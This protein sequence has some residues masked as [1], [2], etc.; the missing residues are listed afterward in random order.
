[1]PRDGGLLAKNETLVIDPFVHGCATA[2]AGTWHS[3]LSS[4]LPPPEDKGNP[5][6]DPWFVP[7]PLSNALRFHPQDVVL[8]TNWPCNRTLSPLSDVIRSHMELA[9]NI[10]ARCGDDIRG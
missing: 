9:D 6:P 4:K 5:T 8:W 7:A 10:N 2:N 1:M 3:M